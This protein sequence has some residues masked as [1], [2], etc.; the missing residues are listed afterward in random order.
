MMTI[1]ITQLLQNSDMQ[2]TQH[3]SY[4]HPVVKYGKRSFDLLFSLFALT[5]L[6]P[7]FV[8]VAIA[9]KLDSEGPVF[10]L[11]TRLGKSR[12]GQDK[13]FNIIKFFYFSRN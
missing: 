5:L 3:S 2:L 1:Q 7:V 13:L 6:A 11:Q 12:A 4:S 10:Y 8:L 9:I